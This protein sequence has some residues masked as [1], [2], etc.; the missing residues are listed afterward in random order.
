MEKDKIVWLAEEY[1]YHKKTADWYWYFGIITL[2]LIAFSFYVHN[3]LFAFVIG[4]GSFTMI[5]YATKVPEIIEHK[6]TSREIIAGKTQYPYSSLASFWISLPK[7]EGGEKILLLHSQKTTMPLFVIPLGDANIEELHEF[8]LN[9]I[10]EK[11]EELPLGQIF[12]NIV[13]F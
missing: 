3:I 2:C 11:E 13:G 12:M 5:L 7:K 10:E 8:L 1:L 6:A 4:I 9:F